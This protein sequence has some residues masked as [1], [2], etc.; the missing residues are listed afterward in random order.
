MKLRFAK[1]NP[2]GNTTILILDPLPREEYAGLALKLMDKT[3]LCAEQVGYLE[4]PEDPQAMARLHMMGGEFCG[5]ATRSFAAFL[6]FGGLSA[7]VGE[8]EEALPFDF[9]GE[10]EIVIE[11]SGHSGPLTAK[12]KETGRK[13]AC[14]VE[15]AMPLPLS[16]QHGKREGLGRYSIVVF[17][18]IV[19]VILWGRDPDQTLL[20]AVSDFLEAESFS[21]ECFG[22]LFYD[23]KSGR[24]I[25]LVSVSSVG[26]VVWE[27]SCGSGSV[28][29]VSARADLEKKSIAD[30][31]LLQPGG[32]LTVSVER[33]ADGKITEANLSGI[34][35][36]IATGVVYL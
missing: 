13:A 30:C 36:V 1:M 31:Q 33:N 22:V 11:V 8:K 12:V 35:S 15:I 9:S 10:K 14:D 16:V 6:A 27:S 28:A 25:P 23:E 24:M 19:H 21:T 34:V 17:E 4:K 32:A 20:P 2:A 26:S 5:N 18:G 7:L 29:V 3:C